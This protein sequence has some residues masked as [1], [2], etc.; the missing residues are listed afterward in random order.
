MI[1]Y[2]KCVE[3]RKNG[4]SRKQAGSTPLSYDSI[5]SHRWRHVVRRCSATHKKVAISGSKAC[6]GDIIQS[7]TVEPLY[8]LHSEMLAILVLLP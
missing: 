2:I 4:A 6:V 5:A 3:L 8:L 1:F 7:F